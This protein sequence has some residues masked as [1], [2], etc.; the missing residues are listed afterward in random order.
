[1]E[2]VTN[3][4]GED[5]DDFVVTTTAKMEEQIRDLTKVQDG[6][7]ISIL[8]AN[9]NYR[10]TYQILLDIAKIWDQIAEEDKITGNNRQNALLE[11]M[12]GKLLP[13]IYGNIFS[14][15][16]ITARTA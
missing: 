10:S 16:Y 7:G 11:L 13:G 4:M 14:R 6:W 12:A 9:G 5:V 3:R 1:M 2:E 8:D 15:T